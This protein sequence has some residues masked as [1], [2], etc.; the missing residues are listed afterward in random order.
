MTVEARSISVRYRRVEALRDVSVTARRGKVTAVLGPNG[1]G[2]TTLL[3]AL[4]GALRPSAGAVMLDGEAIQSVARRHRA[5]RLAYVAQRPL[6][7][8]ALTV[9]ETV[10]LGRFALPMR[11]ERVDAALAGQEIADLADRRVTTL[12]AGQQQRVALARALAQVEPDGM[13]VLDEPAAALDFARVRALVATLRRFAQ[14]GGGVIVTVHDIALASALADVVWILDDGQIVADAP[15]DEVLRPER[16]EPIFG[17]PFRSVTDTNGARVLMPRIE[18]E[19]A[20][21]AAYEP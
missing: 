10:E 2:K 15:A 13:L 21:R 16:L 12:S 18:D 11:Q 20:R 19:G 4:I 9:R 1:A 7:A 8:T 17:V 14:S 3:R 5:A 6:M